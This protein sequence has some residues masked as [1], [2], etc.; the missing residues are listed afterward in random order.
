MNMVTPGARSAGPAT[1][2]ALL[3][4]LAVAACAG[5]ASAADARSAKLGTPFELVLEG[6]PSTG[7]RWQLNEA[8]SSGLDSVR[9]QA[10]GYRS[11]PL[12]GRIIVGAP[13]PFLFR[14]TCVKR[15]A[16]NLR[17]DYAAPARPRSGKTHEMRLRCQ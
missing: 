8:G 2:I 16:A 9:V 13:A 3:G 4:A 10:L 12:R 6:N 7:Y 5:L 14:I 15:G 11:R 17:F 1:R